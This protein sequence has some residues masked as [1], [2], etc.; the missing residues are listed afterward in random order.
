MDDIERYDFWHR[1]MDA[2]MKKVKEDEAIVAFARRIG[3]PL[4]NLTDQQILDIDKQ[5]TDSLACAA[6]NM[7][8]VLNSPM[9]RRL[10]DKSN[11]S[12]GL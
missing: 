12:S 10:F 9:M 3:A 7:K 11:P 2:F 6:S 1:E 5:I 4:D 8:N